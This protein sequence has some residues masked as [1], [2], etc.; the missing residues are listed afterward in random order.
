MGFTED[1]GSLVIKSHAT[2]QVKI[3]SEG[4]EIDSLYLRGKKNLFS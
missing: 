3:T 4:V 2:N 1:L